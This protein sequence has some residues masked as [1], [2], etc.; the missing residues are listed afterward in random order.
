MIYTIAPAEGQCIDLVS[1]LLIFRDKVRK[2][3]RI[4]NKNYT[5]MFSMLNVLYWSQKEAIEWQKNKS[6][7]SGDVALI[8]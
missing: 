4:K 8:P 3:K 2:E 5:K 6:K 7:A 1:N